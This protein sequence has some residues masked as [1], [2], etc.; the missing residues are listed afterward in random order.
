MNKH[1]INYQICKATL[2]GC[3]FG[4]KKLITKDKG[5]IHSASRIPNSKFQIPKSSAATRSMCP[6]KADKP[7]PQ[8]A[9]TIRQKITFFLIPLLFLFFGILH[10]QDLNQAQRYEAQ[11]KLALARAIYKAYLSERPFNPQVYQGYYRTSFGLNEISEFL[12]FSLELLK[13]NPKAPELLIAIGQAYLKLGKKREGLDYLTQVFNIT[14]DLV[15]RIATILASEKMFKDAIRFI[16]DYRKLSKRAT[17]Y[18]SILIDLYEADG[19]Y[20]K[21]TREIVQFLNVNPAHSPNY[22]PKL[23][24]YLTKTNPAVIFNELANLTNQELRAKL[25][26]KLYLSQKNYPQALKEIKSLDSPTAL[27]NF[28]KECEAQE[29]YQIA[30]QLYQE[31]GN[32]SDMARVLRKMGKVTEAVEALKLATGVEAQ[33]ELADLLRLELKDYPN[34]KKNYLSVVKQKP[35]D[36]AYYGLV[37][38]LISLGELSE[39]KNYLKE[40]GKVTDQSLF[41]LIQIYFYE[42]SFDSAQKYIQQLSHNFPTSPFLNDALAIGILIAEGS[43]DLPDYAQATF[44]LAKEQYEEGIKLTQKLIQ[45]TNKVAEYGF[46]LLAQFYLAKKEPNLAL[47][48]LQELKQKFPN[49]PLLPKAKFEQ[50][51]IYSEQLKDKVKEKE[52]LEE[53]IVQFPNSV[54]AVLARNRLNTDKQ[55]PEPIH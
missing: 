2:Q 22:E 50:A 44:H 55:K 25:K 14:P 21:A 12:T 16:L 20:Q 34:A 7:C 1:K 40:M 10:P 52:V 9:P 35:Q 48:A 42:T 23:L 30:V 8:E 4:Q 33:L 27:Y 28:A 13:K 15:G 11:G 19:D 17:G 6:P 24:F 26:S 37:A 32:F 46:L 54:Y 43:E 39:A 18:E 29:Q 31:L 5:K 49:S 47:S 51:K 38:S 41:F 36:Q 3:I 53:L 45:R